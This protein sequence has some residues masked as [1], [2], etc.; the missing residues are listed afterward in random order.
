M[1]A[2]TISASAGLPEPKPV[3][4]A[5][6]G[7]LSALSAAQLSGPAETGQ[8]RA[9]PRSVLERGSQRTGPRLRHGHL[10]TARVPTPNGWT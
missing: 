10:G 8:A 6:A 4:W 9:Q 2:A 1:K 7:C 5:M 3:S